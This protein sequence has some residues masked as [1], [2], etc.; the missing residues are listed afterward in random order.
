MGSGAN[1][2]CT[3]ITFNEVLIVR[4]SGHLHGV[5]FLVL[6]DMVHRFIQFLAPQTQFVSGP[7]NSSMSSA[8]AR[9]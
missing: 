1:E 8:G 2:A 5:R 7:V 3:E 9:S 4:P 6:S